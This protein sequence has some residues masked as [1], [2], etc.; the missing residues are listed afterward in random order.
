[1]VE[2]HYNNSG[3]LVKPITKIVTKDG[4]EMIA[5]CRFNEETYEKIGKN[6][7]KVN[8]FPASIALFSAL[9]STGFG[10][11]NLYSDNLFIL[12]F[13]DYFCYEI[14][15]IKSE[16]DEIKFGRALTKNYQEY[17]TKKFGD[18]YSS[19]KS[20]YIKKLNKQAKEEEQE[21]K[22]L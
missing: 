10:A 6:T 14:L 21:N 18:F 4:C 7:P 9:A 2:D 1:L 22:N 11:F 20:A 8:A 3:K 15:S 16:E 5:R 17:M 12:K 19:K 13:E